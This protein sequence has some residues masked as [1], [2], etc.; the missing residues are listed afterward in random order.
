MSDSWWGPAELPKTTSLPSP[1]GSTCT[2]ISSSLSSSTEF[3]GA[4]VATSLQRPPE[5]AG[6]TMST[7]LTS[8]TVL[9]SSPMSASLPRPTEFAQL[10]PYRASRWLPFVACELYSAA[11]VYKVAENHLLLP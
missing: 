2:S 7:P 6:S 8:S 5:L 9:A 1:T 10:S 11:E 3:A 4:P